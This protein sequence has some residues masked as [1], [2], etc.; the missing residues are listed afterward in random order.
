[1]VDKEN[2]RS[3]APC[4]CTQFPAQ[5][6]ALPLPPPTA[7]PGSPEASCYCPACLKI[8]S[9]SVAVAEKAR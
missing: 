3:D 2:G 8:L 4:W 6:P 9:E 5:F 7:V 1:M